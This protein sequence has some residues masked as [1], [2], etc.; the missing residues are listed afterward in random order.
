LAEKLGRESEMEQEAVNA[1]APMT[2]ALLS[3]SLWTGW[4]PRPLIAT[5]AC[6]FCEDMSDG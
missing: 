3:A 4:K 2:A 6:G 5:A 1:V